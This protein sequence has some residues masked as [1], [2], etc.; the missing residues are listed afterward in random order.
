MPLNMDSYVY[1]FLGDKKGQ[2]IFSKEK[3]KKIKNDHDEFLER[4]HELRRI[5]GIW[6]KEMPEGYAAKMEPVIENVPVYMLMI[7]MVVPMAIL[8]MR[9][10]EKV[11][12]K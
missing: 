7:V 9:L 8:A 3:L 4:Y 12:K 11:L 1:S 5:S 10:A 2:T 6:D